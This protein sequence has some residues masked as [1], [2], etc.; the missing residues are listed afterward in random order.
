[1]Q[2]SRGFDHLERTFP[3]PTDLI[4]HCKIQGFSLRRAKSYR[5]IEYNRNFR[6]KNWKKRKNKNVVFRCQKPTAPQ[7]A[8]LNEF[9][10]QDP[11][12][13]CFLLSNTAVCHCRNNCVF[14]AVRRLCDDRPTAVWQCRSGKQPSKNEKFGKFWTKK[15]VGQTLKE[16]EIDLDKK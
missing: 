11:P 15:W 13:I 14:E 4:K 12:L 1:M 9:G 2:Y 5:K 16:N 3:V 8:P 10:P 6:P 7:T